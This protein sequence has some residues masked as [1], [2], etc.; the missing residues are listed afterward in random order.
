MRKYQR[1]FWNFIIPAVAAVGSALIGKK[2][3]ENTNEA[4]VEL[5]RES[6]AWN[7]EQADIAR[8]FNAEEAHINRSFLA[9]QAGNAMDFSREMANTSYQRAVGDLRAAGLNPMLA[10]SQG[11]APSPQGTSSGG[12][13]AS[14]PSASFGGFHE[15]R[16]SAIAGLNAAATALQMQNLDKQGDNIDADTALKKAQANRETASAGNIEQQTEKLV[17]ADIPKVRKEIVEVEEKIL[18]HRSSQ[19]AQDAR[20]MLD[21]MATMV[22]A[23]KIDLVEAQTALAKIEARLKQLQEPEAKAYA[24]KFKSEW[25]STTTP[26]IR[27]ILDILRTLIYSRPTR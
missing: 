6:M 13:Q 5:S 3:Q 1:G 8:R 25:G 12:S 27:E 2:G 21:K 9:G 15:Q 14:G 20:T 18:S 26:Y 17:T 22:E 4:N 16:S 11:G 24:E 10:Y 23:G 7:G 19:I